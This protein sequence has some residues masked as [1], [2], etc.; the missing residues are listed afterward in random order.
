MNI[1]GAYSRLR[2]LDWLVL[3]VPLAFSVSVTSRD[4]VGRTSHC[5]IRTD[6]ASITR[7]AWA[8]VGVFDVG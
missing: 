2:T 3:L 7:K 1:D 5:A 8:R 4:R 6:T